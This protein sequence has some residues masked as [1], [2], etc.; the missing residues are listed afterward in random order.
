MGVLVAL[1]AGLVFW[2][3]AW[4]LGAKA[5]DGF[6]VTVALVVIAVTGRAVAPFVRQLTRQDQTEPGAPRPPG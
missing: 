4:A 1:A 3:S 2:L 6:L 5:F